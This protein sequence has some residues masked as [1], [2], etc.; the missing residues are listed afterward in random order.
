MP[1]DLAD[2]DVVDDEA[3]VEQPVPD[4]RGE[5]RGALRRIG[6]PQQGAIQEMHACCGSARSVTSW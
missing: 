3:G 5:Q 6:Q 2:L 1:G 4:G